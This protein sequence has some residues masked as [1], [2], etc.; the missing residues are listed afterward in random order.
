ME[1]GG[2]KHGGQAWRRKQGAGG[3]L[4]S[5]GFES[6]APL[7]EDPIMLIE[8]IPLVSGKEACPVVSKE[9]AAPQLPCPFNVGLHGGLLDDIQDRART[10]TSED[11]LAGK[12]Q[13]MCSTYVY[14]TGATALMCSALETAHESM[15]QKLAIQDAHLRH[16]RTGGTG[17]ELS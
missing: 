3:S 6:Q 1:G 17:R 8:T 14:Q 2:C 15:S 11:M 5:L 9:Q 12:S 4:L 10:R 7:I 13:L 16:I